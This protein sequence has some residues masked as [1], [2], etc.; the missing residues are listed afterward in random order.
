MRLIN[1]LLKRIKLFEPK[2]TYQLNTKNLIEK[3]KQ[4][5]KQTKQII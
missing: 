1:A 3:K 4:K 2:K 5:Q